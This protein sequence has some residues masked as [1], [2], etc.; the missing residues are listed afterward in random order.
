MILAERVPGVPGVGCVGVDGV[1]GRGARYEGTTRN[2]RIMLEV[3]E[4]M[5]NT[6]RANVPTRVA[7]SQAL[8]ISA[9]VRSGCEAKYGFTCS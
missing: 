5:A 4:V 3:K 7:S 1:L 9:G 8:S 6:K 2:G